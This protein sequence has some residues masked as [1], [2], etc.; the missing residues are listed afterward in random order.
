M[1]YTPFD[2]AVEEESN[3]STDVNSESTPA[4]RLPRGESTPQFVASLENQPMENQE[5]EFTPEDEFTDNTDDTISVASDA[6]SNI[7]S[8]DSLTQHVSTQIS[9][10]RNVRNLA[11]KAIRAA[12]TTQIKAIRNKLLQTK[13]KL[14]P[15]FQIGDHVEIYKSFLDTNWS[16]KLEDQWAG[17]Y[18]I[19]KTKRRGTYQLK[20]ITGDPPHLLCFALIIF[21]S[22][23]NNNNN[24]SQDQEFSW[25][26]LFLDPILWSQI[27]WTQT[28]STPIPAF[29]ADPQQALALGDQDAPIFGDLN[30]ILSVG[31]CPIDLLLQQPLPRDWPVQTFATG[32]SHPE[33][34]SMP[35]TSPSL[36]IPDND[37]V[38]A[39]TIQHLSPASVPASAVSPLSLPPNSPT[40]ASSVSQQ[41]P[42]LTGKRPMLRPAPFSSP[43][44]SAASSNYSPATTSSA[45]SSSAT[46]STVSSSA[47][48]TGNMLVR[49]I[50][51]THRLDRTTRQNFMRY[52]FALRQNANE[53]HQL[54]EMER[55]ITERRMKVQSTIRQ[56]ESDLCLL[57]DTLETRTAVTDKANKK[58]RNDILGDIFLND[59]LC[60]SSRPN[61]GAY[62]KHLREQMIEDAGRASTPAS[63]M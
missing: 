15:P 20:T 17:P 25:D 38:L 5:L 61:R 59:G 19:H 46:S 52:Y 53:Y 45:V 54:R 30:E 35:M 10:L 60:P 63:H 11:S 39:A 36:S 7:S 3:D 33:L 49:R 48:D 26:N 37:L 44:F 2:R 14:G 28:M 31:T 4:D 42:T 41:R 21:S 40:A 22:T 6:V 57:V 43:S 55:N 34:S 58:I 47:F 12:Q 62:L 13:K 24:T 27:D 8:T 50:K 32:N 9:L 16:G 51:N 29:Q 18:I 56:T 1:P 23:M